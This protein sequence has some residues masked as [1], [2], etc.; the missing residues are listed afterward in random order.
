MRILR[1][2]VGCLILILILSSQGCASLG[3]RNQMSFGI[4]A[5]RNQ[6]WD[7]AIFRWKKILQENPNSASAHNN[8]AI[9]YEK[10]GFWDDA[11]KEYLQALKIDPEN[12]RI[13]SNYKKFQKNL[14]GQE[15]EP[16][17]NEK[18]RRGDLR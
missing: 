4:E 5:A 15:E 3:S 16:E 6:L 2:S 9:A 10:K 18:K 11:E 12:D 8:L 1:P 17:E 13:Q 14:E 7:E